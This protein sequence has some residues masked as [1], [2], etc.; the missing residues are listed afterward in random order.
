MEIFSVSCNCIIIPDKIIKGSNAGIIRVNHS[1]SPR[2]AYCRLSAG[3]VRIQPVRRKKNTRV[4]NI[5]RL[6]CRN[7]SE[8]LLFL[9]IYE[10]GSLFYAFG[11]ILK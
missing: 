8:Q 9:K 4:A 3:W 1:S 5:P 6:Y 10:I 7:Y 2:E 11:Q